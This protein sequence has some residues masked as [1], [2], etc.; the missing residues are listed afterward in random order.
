MNSLFLEFYNK[1]KKKLEE[2]IKEFNNNLKE[3]NQIINNNLDSFKK[4]NSNGKLIR[5]I[6]IELGYYLLS[7]DTKYAM[8]LALA[9]EVFQTSILVHDDII[10]QDDIRRDVKTI[11]SV[12]KDNYK[13]INDKNII[14][15]LSNSIALCMGDYGL[16]TANKIIT[17]SYI[18]DDN[19]G[20][21]LTCYNDI[22]LK[23]IKGEILDVVLPYDSKYKGIEIDTLKDS[24]M[25][26]YK[27]KTAYYTIIGPLILG[28][29]LKGATTKQKEDI[30]LFGEKVGIAFQI[31][32]DILGIFN[33]NIGKITGSDIKEYKQTLM[34]YYIQTTKYKDEFNKIYGTDDLSDENIT[35]IK[36]LLIKSKSYEYA[37][38]TMNN[39][40]DESLDLLNN[41]S[42]IDTNKKELLRGFV[43][44]LR[45]RNK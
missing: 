43:E 35:R 24:I 31:Q 22:V 14:N 38:N 27:L 5:G 12:N 45:N 39:L 36:E 16:F 15:H 29:T 41:I 13:I 34:Y 28:L 10:D 32:D 9:Y 25:N 7:N 8:D 6:L 3:D 4:L 17:E 26:I 23:T 37:H 2:K 33:D 18:N 30:E 42:W 40:Y 20:K 19:L 21:I 1:E 11:H 44:F